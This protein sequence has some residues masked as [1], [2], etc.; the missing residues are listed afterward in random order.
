MARKKK[1]AWALFWVI[2]WFFVCR[3]PNWI[4]VMATMFR[5]KP[6]TKGLV[7]LK[8]ALVFLSVLNTVVNPWLYSR[9]NEPLK[10]TLSSCTDQF[11]EP[12]SSVCSC[13]SC[14]KRGSTCDDA[15]YPS[16]DSEKN[17][18]RPSKTS[19]TRTHHQPIRPPSKVSRGKVE[20]Y[21][22]ENG[23]LNRQSSNTNKQSDSS[24]SGSR[25]N[26]ASHQYSG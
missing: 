12:F 7:M 10:K 23:S 2:F 1:V 8:S 15:E 14:G 24:R 20:P 3:M 6:F 21:T 22:I 11:C 17:S 9:L 19:S 18:N 26:K 13:L 4:F 16:N 25:T 5:S